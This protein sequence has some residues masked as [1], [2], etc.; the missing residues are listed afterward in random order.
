MLAVHCTSLHDIHSVCP[1]GTTKPTTHPLFAHITHIPSSSTDIMKIFGQ[2][3]IFGM[4]VLVL[5]NQVMALVMNVYAWI[6]STFVPIA[7]QPKYAV[8]PSGSTC[9][10]SIQGPGGLDQ[11]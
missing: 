3:K 4:D 1:A 5:K 7:L 8:P 11:V 10:V 9:C 6:I 2:E